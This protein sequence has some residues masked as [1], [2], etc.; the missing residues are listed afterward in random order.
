MCGTA[1]ELALL[2][3]ALALRKGDVYELAGAGCWQFDAAEVEACVEELGG[4]GEVP[5]MR[6]FMCICMCIGGVCNDVG[7]GASAH[8]G[9]AG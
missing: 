9:S 2:A 7:V 5:R 8:F 1:V 3:L 6:L 4:C